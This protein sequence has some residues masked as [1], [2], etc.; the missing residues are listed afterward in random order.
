MPLTHLLLAIAVMA[1]WGTN[2]VVIAFALE[3]LPPLLLAA[4]RFTLVFFPMA[5]FVKRPQVPLSNLAAYGVLIGAGQ[6]GLLFLALKGHI[7]PGLASLLVQ[8]QIFFTIGLS[9]RTSGERVGAHQWLALA[10]ATSGIVLIFVNNGGGASPLGIALV[11]GAALCWSLGNITARKAGGAPMLPYIVWSS[12]FAVPPLALFAFVF[13]GWPA[14]EHGLRTAD[15]ASWVAVLW[16]SVG[17]T[18]FGYTAWQWLLTKHPAAVVTP[19]ALLVPVFGMSAS[20]LVLAEPMPPWKLIAAALVLA[21]L[22]LN[23]MWPLI[24]GRLRRAPSA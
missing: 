1:V 7:T 23:L 16:Q 14:I 12:I 18:M 2:F 22:A 8:S 4:L 6:F 13:E 9:M 3:H 19:M 11:L 5:L 20:A 17:N 21:G 15:A 24:A 10:L